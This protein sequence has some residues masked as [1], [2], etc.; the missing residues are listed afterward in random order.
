M[1]Q[2]HITRLGNLQWER[3]LVVTVKKILPLKIKRRK[4]IHFS[5]RKEKLLRTSIIIIEI[6]A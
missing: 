5:F 3:T 6:T 1:R 2:D 4:N